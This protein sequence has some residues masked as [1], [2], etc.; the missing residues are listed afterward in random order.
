MVEVGCPGKFCRSGFAC[1]PAFGR[2]VAPLARL[3]DGTRERVPFRFWGSGIVARDVVKLVRVGA[4]R[5]L[6]EINT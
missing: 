5:T 1:T 4:L 2:A 3:F 6:E